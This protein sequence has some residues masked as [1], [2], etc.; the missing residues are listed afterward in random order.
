MENNEIIS[1]SRI[2]EFSTGMTINEIS[3]NSGLMYFRKKIKLRV[4]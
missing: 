1:P 3:T 2:Q 4:L